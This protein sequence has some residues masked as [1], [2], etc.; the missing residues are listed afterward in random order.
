LK[1]ALSFSNFIGIS[2]PVQKRLIDDKKMPQEGFPIY[3]ILKERVFTDQFG[4][5]KGNLNSSLNIILAMVRGIQS[6]Y[7][8]ELATTTAHIYGEGE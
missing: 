8:E 6:N 4:L 7:I 3:S 2:I 1:Q 5:C